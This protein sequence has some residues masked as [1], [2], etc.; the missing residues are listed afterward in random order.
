MAEQTFRS[1]GFFEQE[2]DLSARKQSPTGT[3]A[4]IIG[5]AQRGPAFVPVTVGSFADFETKFG[6]LDPDRFGP[7]AVREFLKHRRAVTYMR[8]LGAGS[9]ESSAEMSNTETFNIVKNAGF[10]VQ[11]NDGI[12]TNLLTTNAWASMPGADASADDLQGGMQFL[13]A[14]HTVRP[15]ESEGFPIFTDNDSFD[16]AGGVAGAS[17]A[18]LVRA[19]IMMASGSRMMIAGDVA[20]STLIGAAAPDDQI[21]PDA[22]GIFKL[23]ISSSAGADFGLDDN[24]PGLRILF[25]IP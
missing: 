22:S 10:S 6:G 23:I 11:T 5:T 12:D 9:N 1:P 20:V 17:P 16:P 2:I 19:S 15:L 14:R 13:V 3:P 8:V 7:Y 21:T 24:I 4:G 18:N 25:C